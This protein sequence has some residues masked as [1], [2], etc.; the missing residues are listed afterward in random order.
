MQCF[1]QYCLTHPTKMISISIVVRYLALS[2]LPYRSPYH[3]INSIK[4]ESKS[5]AHILAIRFNLATPP[6]LYMYALSTRLSVVA[7]V[8]RKYSSN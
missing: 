3:H 1:D 7:V 5:K 2:C 4:V 8:S 6:L